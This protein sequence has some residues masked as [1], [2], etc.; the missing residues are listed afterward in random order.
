MV[1]ALKRF[2]ILAVMLASVLLLNLLLLLFM[3]RFEPTYYFNLQSLSLMVLAGIAGVTYWRNS[4]AVREL[5]TLKA[6]QESYL[7]LAFMTQNNVP[8]NELLQEVLEQAV[9][10]NG[11]AQKGSLSVLTEEGTMCFRCTVGFD[12]DTLHDVK[13]RL[14]DTFLA[15]LTNNRFDRSVTVDDMNRFNLDKGLKKHDRFLLRFAAPDSI[16]S[17]LSTPIFVNGKL[18]G[19]FN[20]DSVNPHVFKEHHIKAA[21]MYSFIA[22][23]IIGLHQNAKALKQLAD[24]DPLTD[25]Y[26]RQYLE[27]HIE[28]WWGGHKK[29]RVIMV[30]MDNLK[31]INDNLGHAL[32]DKAIELF[33]DL[34]KKQFQHD[35][36][37]A[38]VGGDEFVI[39]STKA[40]DDI[41]AKCDALNMQLNQ[42]HGEL[43]GRLGFSY[44][45]CLLSDDWSRALVDAD[46]IMYQAKRSKKRAERM[47]EQEKCGELNPK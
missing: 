16:M 45:H 30:D 40:P 12:L 6:V 4:L 15:K 47:Q 37:V 5:T 38:R 43:E 11:S 10:L 35:D 20:L 27:T 22:G 44:G 21:E 29:S 18:H 46:K 34:L 13:L 1:N 14:E 3:S 23:N 42:V 17:T 9:K 19:T 24:R 32:G 26:N 7:K 31:W 28:R 33:S 36:I 39:L 41:D 25:C 2:P 8:E